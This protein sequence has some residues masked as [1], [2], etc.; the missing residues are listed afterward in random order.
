[1]SDERL[2]RMESKLDKVVD[3]LGQLNVTLSRN[4]DSLEYHVKRTD[5]LEAEIHPMK[6]HL[7]HIEVKKAA[8]QSIMHFTK[9]AASIAAAAT[10]VAAFVLKLM[11]KM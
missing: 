4:T 8:R 3:Q 7:A 1:M 10:A 11:G 9:W 5:I 6:A 2:E